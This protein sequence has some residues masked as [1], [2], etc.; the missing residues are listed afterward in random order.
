[1]QNWTLSLWNYVM[2]ALI[3]DAQSLPPGRDS[4]STGPGLLCSK[5][6][7]ASS[8]IQHH[9]ES[10]QPH[11]RCH[12]ILLDVSLVSAK[13]KALFIK[14]FFPTQKKMYNEGGNNQHK[15]KK[16]KGTCTAICPTSCSLFWS[17]IGRLKVAGIEDKGCLPGKGY[18]RPSLTHWVYVW[19]QS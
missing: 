14:F 6:S 4:S 3:F 5:K 8:K 17:S 16:A 19:S 12:W 10:L 18:L 7:L 1:M 15:L 2:M 11:G 9:N 13:G